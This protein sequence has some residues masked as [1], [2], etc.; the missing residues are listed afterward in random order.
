MSVYVEDIS[1]LSREA[2]CEVLSQFVSEFISSA[3][4]FRFNVKFISESVALVHGAEVSCF[5]LHTWLPVSRKILQPIYNR[6]FRVLDTSAS[7]VLRFFPWTDLW[8]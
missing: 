1:N 2:L 5:P 3:G 7:L 6:G 8:D 4:R